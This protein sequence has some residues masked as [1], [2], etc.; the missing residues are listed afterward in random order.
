MRSQFCSAPKPSGQTALY[1]KAAKEGYERPQL[2]FITRTSQSE[3]GDDDDKP[4]KN[5]ASANKKEERKDR[6]EDRKDEG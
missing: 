4:A 3:S 2:W 1:S 6:E 5:D